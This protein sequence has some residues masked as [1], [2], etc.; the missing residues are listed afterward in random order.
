MK[1]RRNQRAQ[2]KPEEYKQT[3]LNDIAGNEEMTEYHRRVT[4]KYDRDDSWRASGGNPKSENAY[5]R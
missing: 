1:E 5:D 2:F 4:Q 3:F